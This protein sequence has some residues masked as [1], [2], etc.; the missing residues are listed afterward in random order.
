MKS[1]FFIIASVIV[2]LNLMMMSQFV[3]RTV[4]NLHYTGAQELA[5][6]EDIRKAV[7]QIKAKPEF[8]KR[9]MRLLEFALRRSTA[10]NFQ[11]YF[12]CSNASGGDLMLNCEDRHIYD[13]RN[14]AHMELELIGLYVQAKENISLS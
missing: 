5:T 9:D 11:L 8:Y 4:I 13:L 7:A 2:L 14:D 10:F 3:R 6:A 1:Q 12:Q